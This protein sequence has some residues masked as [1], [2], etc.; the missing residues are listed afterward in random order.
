MESSVI[1]EAPPILKPE[2]RLYYDEK[3][4]VLFYT[5]EKPEG[6][7]IVIDSTTYAQG[8]PDVR[9]IDGKIISTNAGSIISKLVI[10]EQGVTCAEE[11]MSII[12]DDSYIGNTNKW[13]LITYELG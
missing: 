13:K 9:V 4:Y 2:F 3:G 1:W 12:V 11:D 10:A 5:C 8:R 7:Y 6:N